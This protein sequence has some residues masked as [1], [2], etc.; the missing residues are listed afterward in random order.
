[1]FHTEMHSARRA[2]RLEYS[3]QA[4]QSVTANSLVLYLLCLC[5]VV[6]DSGTYME[7]S[8]KVQTERE[9]IS[10]VWLGAVTETESACPSHAQGTAFMDQV[11]QAMRRMFRRKIESDPK[12]ARLKVGQVSTI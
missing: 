1:M 7:S 5:N 10:N 11:A 12:Y 3:Q 8:M 6:W 4:L 2:F 9:I